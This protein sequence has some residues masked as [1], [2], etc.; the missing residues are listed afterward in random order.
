MGKGGFQD[1]SY[2]FSLFQ[3][4]VLVQVGIPPAEESIPLG[5]MFFKELSYFTSFRFCNVFEEVLALCASGAVN[6]KDLIS[7][8]FPFDKLDKAIQY[9]GEVED[10]I[11]IQVK[12]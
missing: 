9:T 1:I 2:G 5:L 3:G 4:A 10:R 8:T 7:R 12:I 6:V 11:K